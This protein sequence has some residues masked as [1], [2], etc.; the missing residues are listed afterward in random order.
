MGFFFSFSRGMKSAV[1]LLRT[2]ERYGYETCR[3]PVPS[4]RR[5]CVC[6]RVT[7]KLAAG[8]LYVRAALRVSLLRECDLVSELQNGRSGGGGGGGGAVFEAPNIEINKKGAI[9][10]F[11]PSLPDSPSTPPNRS[12]YGREEKFVKMVS[13]NHSPVWRR[14]KRRNEFFGNAELWAWRA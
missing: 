2:R 10:H 5:G 8:Q 3:A 12:A 13:A 14:V 7:S 6:A 9:L 1:M 4:H 11:K